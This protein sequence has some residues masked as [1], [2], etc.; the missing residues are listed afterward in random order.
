[1]KHVQK[2]YKQKGQEYRKR[3]R[4]NKDILNIYVTFYSFDSNM[5]YFLNQGEKDIY[6]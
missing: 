4:I 3:E 5:T 2:K 1:M 6:I